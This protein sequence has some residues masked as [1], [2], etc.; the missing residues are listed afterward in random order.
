MIPHQQRRQL[1]V[2]LRDEE[3]KLLAMV[4]AGLTHTEIARRTF[5]GRSNV[6]SKCVRI[7]RKIGARNAANAVA[8]A[9]Q[10]GYIS[11]NGAVE[12]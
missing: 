12:K 10:M 8:I 2:P 11:V 3:R 4:A 5:G 6:A 7:Y 1:R 9:I